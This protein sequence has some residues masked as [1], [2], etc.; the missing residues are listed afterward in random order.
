MATHQEE[1]LNGPQHQPQQR[2][3]GQQSEIK[4]TQQFLGIL[5]TCIN[6]ANT[7]CKMQSCPKCHRVRFFIEVPII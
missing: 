5:N 3:V 7:N 2:P 6:H 4:P 1:N